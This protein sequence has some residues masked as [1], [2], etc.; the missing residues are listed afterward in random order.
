M[1]VIIGWSASARPKPLPRLRVIEGQ[2]Q[3]LP[4]QPG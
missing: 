3:R 4:H 1:F 2:R